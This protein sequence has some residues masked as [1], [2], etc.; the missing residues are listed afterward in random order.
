MSGLQLDWSHWGSCV[1]C[2]FWCSVLYVLHVMW[3][4]FCVWNNVLIHNI[5]C[6]WTR[7]QVASTVSSRP[8]PS[9]APSAGWWVIFA[10]CS[11]FKC[12]CFSHGFVFSPQC[13]T[14]RV[15]WFHPQAGEERQR[16]CE[17]R[18]L[19]SVIIA[20]LVIMWL[21]SPQEHLSDKQLFN[22]MWQNPNAALVLLIF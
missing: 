21:F 19:F 16:C 5:G 2:P 9:V 12:I 14:G 18:R 15:G 13:T 7:S 4:S 11:I 1:Y 20:D 10:L 6:R 3:I 22:K 17:V 8:T